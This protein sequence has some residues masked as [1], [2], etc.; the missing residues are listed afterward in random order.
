MVIA[1]M[2]RRVGVV[3]C[4][5][6]P[7]AWA[8]PGVEGHT[9]S[10]VAVPQGAP[11]A[12][13][14]SPAPASPA[15]ASPV[16]S[17]LDTAA[18]AAAS[19]AFDRGAQL[20]R[21]AEYEAALG[22]FE[23]AYQLAPLFPTL[24]YIGAANVQLGRWAPARRAFELYLELGNGQLPPERIEEVRLDLEELKKNT[25]TL[26]LTLNV[27]GA[28]V[29]LDGSPLQP[30][31][32]TGLVVEP[33]QH[34][35]R[36]TKQGFLPLEQVLEANQGEDVHV[37]LPL[38]RAV[39]EANAGPLSP[40]PPGSKAPG[41]PPVPPDVAGSRVPLWMPWTLTGVLAA[42]WATTAV[43]AVQ[44]RHD[45]DVIEQPGTSAARIDS[46]RDLHETLAVVSDVLL[47]STL[48]S[49]G[50]SAYLTWWPETS[51]AA[52]TKRP[53]GASSGGM[54]GLNVSGQF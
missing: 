49:A 5:L 43:L 16:P 12:S 15:P 28:D 1:R 37:V 53:S 35:V 30:T 40:A 36:V 34:V 14:A 38:A 4:L 45:R 25:A 52:A 41:T 47:V 3:A 13:P 22:E 23:H 51:S 26:T 2:C 10:P 6:T 8:E 33:G 50:V 11:P 24:Y 7:P 42:G 31:K 18:L 32:I 29:H 17:A 9:A 39:T 54:W 46:A 20:Y 48:A 44:V 27:G 21:Q 19:A